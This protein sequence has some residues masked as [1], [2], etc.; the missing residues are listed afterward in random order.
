VVWITEPSLKELAG[1]ISSGRFT[2]GVQ[3]VKINS[4][5]EL[6]ENARDPNIVVFI[7]AHALENLDRIS[8]LLPAYV[9]GVA[10]DTIAHTISWLGPRTWLAHVV[11]ASLFEH[12]LAVEHMRNLLGSLTS[13]R[14]IRLLDWISTDTEGRRVKLAHAS[15]RGE[16]LER[17]VEYLVERGISPRL[18]EQARDAAE[19]LLTN[20][21]YD[22]PVSA[23]A[24]PKPISRTQDV[25]LPEKN[26]CDLA[27]GCRGGELAIVRVRDPFGSLTRERLTEVLL[28]C[29]RSDMD[30]RVDE[31]M[32]GAGLGMWKVF[33]SALFVAV[34]VVRQHHTEI[35]VGIG[36]R[37]PGTKPFAFHLFFGEGR[38]RRFWNLFNDESNLEGLNRSV[39]LELKPD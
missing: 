15:K 23:G 19:E 27:Y 13:N 6:L 8:A 14:E 21:F 17:M 10:H 1:S 18:V 2:E 38:K 29:S 37:P 26:A 34:S 36:K 16:R 20:A 25:E 22:A 28:R 32:G 7:D 39:M 31:S 4:T 30:V 9:V 3:G 5:K 12:P 33:S 35:L 24:M 11:S